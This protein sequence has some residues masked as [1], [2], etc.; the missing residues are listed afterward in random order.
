M[1]YPRGDVRK[2]VGNTALDVRGV[3]EAGDVKGFTNKKM[4]FKAMGW[5]K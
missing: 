5:M 2:T 4:I 1:Q 3:S